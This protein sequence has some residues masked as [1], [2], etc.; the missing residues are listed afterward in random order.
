MAFCHW[1]CR[2]PGIVAGRGF[3]H[4]G[5]GVRRQ[6]KLGC[7]LAGN[8]CRRQVVFLQGHVSALQRG[9]VL[10]DG[11]LGGSFRG[12]EIG[13]A[14]KANQSL[15]SSITQ[16]VLCSN[17]GEEFGVQFDLPLFYRSFRRPERG[18]H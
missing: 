13:H 14:K 16:V 17:F 1:G 18:G 2:L 4:G 10:R 3:N 9:E 6:A 11:K 12:G 5:A 7:E 8:P 15:D